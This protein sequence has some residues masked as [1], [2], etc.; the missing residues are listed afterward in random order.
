[1]GLNKV[2]VPA[3]ALVAAL[4]LA[5]GCGSDDT[6]AVAA[7]CKS[8]TAEAVSKLDDLQSRLDVGVNQEEYSRLVG[9]VKSATDRLSRHDLSP[10]CTRISR[11]LSQVA[12]MHARTAGEW[13]DCIIS[14]YC[15]PDPS[16]QWLRAQDGYA[17]VLVALDKLTPK[18]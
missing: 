16:P 17:K 15:T 8:Q 13:N 1:M 3:V 14:T 10:E 18:S 7:T 5:A 9:N 6:A 2:P 4:A 12:M 11:G